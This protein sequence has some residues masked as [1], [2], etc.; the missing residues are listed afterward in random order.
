MQLQRN[1][2]DHYSKVVFY[3]QI[4]TNCR[5]ENQKLQKQ[6]VVHPQ[7]QDN[8]CTIKEHKKLQAQVADLR[9]EVKE[10]KKENGKIKEDSE[11]AKKDNE[12]QDNKLLDTISTQS[13]EIQ[14]LI[15][16]YHQISLRV[17][18]DVACTKQ[19][20]DKSTQLSDAAQALIGH[21]AL[22]RQASKSAHT[23]DIASISEAVLASKGANRVSLIE[24]FRY[25]FECEPELAIE[26]ELISSFY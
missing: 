13:L 14:H 20:Q 19:E 15:K 25:C 18:L 23:T 10:L 22:H 7:Q 4:H 2:L 16:M 8:Y 6:K 5:V 26:S 17:L 3:I 24:L 12:Q 21:S 1:L 9:E 11:Q